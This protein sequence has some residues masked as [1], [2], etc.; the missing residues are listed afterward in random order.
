[1]DELEDNK[2]ETFRG[3]VLL[4]LI[5]ETNSLTTLGLRIKAKV[6]VP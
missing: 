2:I 3:K 5:A 1:M 6:T 4:I